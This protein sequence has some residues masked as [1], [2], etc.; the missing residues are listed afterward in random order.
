MAHLQSA[1]TNEGG[2]WLA[3]VV[4]QVAT[5]PHA[6]RN[7]WPAGSGFRVQGSRSFR[8][9]GSGFKELQGSG[10]FRVQ[11]ASGF[12]ELQGASRSFRDLQGSGFR[13]QVSGS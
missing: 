9:Q 6:M 3:R 8:V 12:R 5:A 4:P 1:A 13:F 10:N 11:G 7:M 2:L